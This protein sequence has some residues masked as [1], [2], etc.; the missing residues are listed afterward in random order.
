MLI[1]LSAWPLC[2]LDVRRGP[3]DLLVSGSFEAVASSAA[4]HN[5]EVSLTTLF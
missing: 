5:N 3:Y 4:V 1:A 2:G